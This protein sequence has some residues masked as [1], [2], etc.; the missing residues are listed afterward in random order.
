MHSQ[1]PS[2]ILAIL[3]PAAKTGGNKVQQSNLT[4]QLEIVCH[5]TIK[6]FPATFRS[7]LNVSA[8]GMCSRFCRDTS[9]DLWVGV[10]DYQRGY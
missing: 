1:V 2:P 10:S 6:Q 4:H 8:S 7:G 5:G 9:R 3:E